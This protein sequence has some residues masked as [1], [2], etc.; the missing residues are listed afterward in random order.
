MK[1][2]MRSLQTDCNTFDKKIEESYK[3]T[4]CQDVKESGVYTVYPDFKPSGL[5]IYC[6]IDRDMAWSVIQ[7]RKDG[8]VKP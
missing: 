3:H 1:S 4:S 7:R 5:K 8:T 6:E 2:D